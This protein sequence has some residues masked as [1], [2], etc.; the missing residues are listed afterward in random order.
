MLQSLTTEDFNSG[1]ELFNYS[2]QDMDYLFVQLDIALESIIEEAKRLKRAHSVKYKL[3]IE[4]VTIQYLTDEF[5]M[6]AKYRNGNSDEKR[7]AECY[8]LHSAF[9]HPLLVIDE[10]GRRIIE[11]CDKY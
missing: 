11:E 2:K 8:F 7:A 5:K 1:Y 9:V 10:Y 4:T 6:Y 3:P